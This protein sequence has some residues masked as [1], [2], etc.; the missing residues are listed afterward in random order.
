[1]KDDERL[2]AGVAADLDVAEREAAPAEAERLHRGFLGR[3]AARDVLGERAL[4]PALAADL[5]L[6]EDAREESLAVALEDAG[7]AVDLG[8]VQAEQK[9]DRAAAS[10]E[11]L[12]VEEAGDLRAEGLRALRAAPPRGALSSWPA[13]CRRRSSTIAS[14]LST[15]EGFACRMGASVAL[16]ISMSTDSVSGPDRR[17]ARLARQQADLAEGRS[18]LEDRHAPALDGRAVRGD[19]D[20]ALRDQ[21]HGRARLALAHDGLA[22][23]EPER[24]ERRR[25]ASRV[26]RLESGA[27]SSLRLDRR[28][29]PRGKRPGRG[30]G[31]AAYWCCRMTG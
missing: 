3:E 20:P 22:L 25:R 6:A 26:P 2:S 9:A 18:R 15:R 4:V 21:E 8:Q 11:A 30:S 31:P 29:G 13:V 24:G 5:A 16:S 12:E 19:A 14:S 27:K 28:R 7:D 1:M 23:G 10:G 17:E